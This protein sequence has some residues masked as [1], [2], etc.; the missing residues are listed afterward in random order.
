MFYFFQNLR[1][2][3]EAGENEKLKRNIEYYPEDE[4]PDLLSR[5]GAMSLHCTTDDNDYDPCDEYVL[6]L[7]FSLLSKEGIKFPFLFDLLIQ[8]IYFIK[9]CL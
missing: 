7:V 1:A 2:C 8:H 4:D 6:N 9:L 3:Y 5:L